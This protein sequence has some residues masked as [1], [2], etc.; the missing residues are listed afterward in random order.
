MN[1]VRFTDANDPGYRKV[2]GELKE[3]VQAIWMQTQQQ[4]QVAG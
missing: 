2:G 3:L 4:C 1:M